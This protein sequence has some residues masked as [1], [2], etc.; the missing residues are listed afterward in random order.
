M[1]FVA[2]NLIRVVK[3]VVRNRDRPTV[4]QSA[5]S[6]FVQHLVLEFFIPN[7]SIKQGK[8]IDGIVFTLT[9]TSICTNKYIVLMYLN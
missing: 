7:T 8:L 2:V 9:I 4:V 6:S 1:Q 3:S 5:M